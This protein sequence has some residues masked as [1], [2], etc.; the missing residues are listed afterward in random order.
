MASPCSVWLF[1]S[2]VFNTP[3]GMWLPLSCSAASASFQVDV[4]QACSAE[5]DVC[6]AGKLYFLCVNECRP[7]FSSGLSLPLWCLFFLFYLICY[8]FRWLWKQ[9]IITY[10]HVYCWKATSGGHMHYYNTQEEVRIKSCDVL[11]RRRWRSASS[12]KSLNISESRWWRHHWSLSGNQSE[13][14][15]VEAR[16]LS[17]R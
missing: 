9:L 17:P 1:W 15:L 2:V 4:L 5:C 13:S 8:R 16:H 3:A 6:P 7:S 12:G 10:I 11:M 14:R